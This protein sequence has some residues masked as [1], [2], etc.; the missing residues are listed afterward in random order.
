[1]A[2]KNQKKIVNFDATSM[3]SGQRQFVGFEV[4]TA[5]VMKHYIFKDITP[6]SQLNVKPACYM[7]HAGFILGLFFDR[8]Y[9]GDIFLLN[10]S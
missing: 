5:V 3:F 7:L 4:L 2:E 10:S 9:G 1:V 6:C 8:E